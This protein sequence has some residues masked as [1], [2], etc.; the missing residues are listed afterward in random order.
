MTPLA[1]NSTTSRLT[2]HAAA[3][4]LGAPAYRCPT[5]GAINESVPAIQGRGESNNGR[6][7][8]RPYQP[9][10]ECPGKVVTFAVPES[11]VPIPGLLSLPL[12]PRP[13]IL[14][15]DRWILPAQDIQLA[16]ECADG[17]IFAALAGA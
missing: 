7:M 8:R 6:R 3:P 17:R 1:A 10:R 16:L 15:G 12:R 14:I 4:R 5:P 11:R 2:S 13:L 9:I